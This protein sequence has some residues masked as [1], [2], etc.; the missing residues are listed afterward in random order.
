MLHI[1]QLIY[2]YCINKLVTCES[3]LE[4][5]HLIFLFKNVTTWRQMLPVFCM[6]FKYFDISSNTFLA[7]K[8]N[9]NEKK[10]TPPSVVCHGLPE[11]AFQVNQL[12]NVTWSTTYLCG[13][14]SYKRNENNFLFQRSDCF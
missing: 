4:I 3:T 7:A 11:N 6:I 10:I 8:T 9:Q 1:F 14:Y 12:Y 2:I 5:T 13:K